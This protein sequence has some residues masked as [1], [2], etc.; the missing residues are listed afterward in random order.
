MTDEP[1]TIFYDRECRLCQGTVSFIQRRNHG[2]RFRFVPLGS[3]EGVALLTA[4]NHSCETLHLVD[5]KGHHD[6]STAVLRIAAG[7]GFPWSVFSV[8]HL[9]PKG[10]RDA[11]YNLVARYRLK[12][13]GRARQTS[14]RRD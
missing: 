13:F 4:G 2:G 5:G 12:V 3:K 8:L 1:S 14:C 6:R 11:V 10:W 7:L 9:V